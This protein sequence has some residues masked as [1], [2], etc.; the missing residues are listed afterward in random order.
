[1]HGSP[2]LLMPIF[3]RLA[4]WRTLTDE[5]R[6]AIVA[7]PCMLKTLLPGQYLIAEGEPPKHV[8]VLKSGF[9]YRQKIVG[10]G[11]RQI[12]AIHVS[13]D[14]VDLQHALLDQA[15]HSVQALTTAQVVLLPR[16]AVIALAAARPNVALAMWHET[17]IEAS[18]MREWTANIGRRPA[19]VR[20]AH[21][22]CELLLRLRSAG[23]SEAQ[24]YEIPMTQEQLGD[25]TGMTAIHL[26]RMLM[27]LERAGAIARRGRSVKVLDWN[28]LT[29][30]G[31]FDPAYLH[32]LGTA[33]DL[34][35]L[36][37]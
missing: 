6:E 23:Q 9:M 5:D 32:D 24:T 28:R 34:G 21:L 11:G 20:L 27:Q 33:R 26:N 35:Q 12:L 8:C 29:Q 18:I 19:Q 14:W 1:M 16:E 30:M 3:D 36:A 37:A 4:S 31:D 2:S 7:L 10:N 22:L 25:C 13:G 17:L 15:D